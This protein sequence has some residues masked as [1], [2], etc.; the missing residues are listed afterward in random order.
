M[1]MVQRSKR[2]FPLVLGLILIQA[3]EM[4]DNGKLLESW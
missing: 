1:E 4:P 2:K 3:G